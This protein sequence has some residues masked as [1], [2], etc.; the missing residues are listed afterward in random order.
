MLGKFVFLVN[1]SYVVKFFD[2]VVDMGKKVFNYLDMGCKQKEEKEQDMR[3]K[4]I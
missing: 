1:W 2:W 4:E 3:G